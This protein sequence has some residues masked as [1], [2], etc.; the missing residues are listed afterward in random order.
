MRWK[1]LALVYHIC[2]LSA[3]CLHCEHMISIYSIYVLEYTYTESILSTTPHMRNIIVGINKRVELFKN[4]EL[5]LHKLEGNFL[6]LSFYLKLYF[7]V[8]LIWTISAI[9]LFFYWFSLCTIFIFSQSMFWPVFSNMCFDIT[10]C[11]LG[12]FFILSVCSFFLVSNNPLVCP[13]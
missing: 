7:L 3:Y 11:T 6:N 5:L 4:L 12:S 9:H 2:M 8:F 1:I 10:L 13:R